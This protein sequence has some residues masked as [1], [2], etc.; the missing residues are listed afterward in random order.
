MFI[1]NFIL[2]FLTIFTYMSHMG[3]I[4]IYVFYT[5]FV[6]SLCIR[7]ILADDDGTY[8]GTHITSIF[9]FSQHLMMLLVLHRIEMYTYILCGTIILYP[10]CYRRLVY[11]YSIVLYSSLSYF[12]ISSVQYRNRHLYIF[13]R[14][15]ILGSWTKEGL[16][17]C[18][19]FMSGYAEPQL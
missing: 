18:Y 1:L 10:V 6:F 19:S 3:V 7:Q 17:G 13:V 9:I 15:Q 4:N 11:S 12:S 2:I 5:F 14:K 8:L 16:H